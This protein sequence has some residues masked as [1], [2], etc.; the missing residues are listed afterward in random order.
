MA[1]GACIAVRVGVWRVSDM[2][3]RNRTDWTSTGRDRLYNEVAIAV[4]AEVNHA[5]EYRHGMYRHCY[6]CLSS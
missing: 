6:R 2:P 3:G 4:T 5:D 1:A